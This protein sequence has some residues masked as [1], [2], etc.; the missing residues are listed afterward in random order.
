ML[1]RPSVA[2]IYVEHMR[3]RFDR[4]LVPLFPPDAAE[5]R[6]G[7]IGRF[8]NGE[9]DR[10][11]HLEEILGG[12]DAFE[13]EVALAEA[14]NPGNLAFMSDGSVELSP[15][16][17]VS[18]GGVQLLR[19]KLSFTGTRAVVASFCG[20][21][22]RAVKSP[23]Q[24]DDI[25]WRLYFEQRLREEEVVVFSH[26]R[27]ASGVVLVNRKSGVEVEIMADP[28]LVG[29]V[30]TLEGLGLGPGI[31]FGEGSAVSAR[32]TGENLTVAVKAKGLVGPAADRVDDVRSFEADDDRAL[33]EFEGV[34]VPLIDAQDVI[35]EADFDTP[36]E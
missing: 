3:K 15:S 5:V 21:V 11:G 27:A 8:V 10:R 29:A 22:E 16:V 18:V 17:A 7:T 30:I 20:V 31:K 25:L 32:V 14:T 36:E 35:G 24:F 28:A 9:F 26:R 23:R 1:H 12:A 4:T 34:D 6:V 2:E 19:A 13:R 33:A